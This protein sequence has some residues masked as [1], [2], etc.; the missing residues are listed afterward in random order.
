MEE[1]TSMQMIRKNREMLIVAIIIVLFALY[2]GYMD[3]R[4]DKNAIKEEATIQN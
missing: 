3:G 1:E 4:Y 2:L